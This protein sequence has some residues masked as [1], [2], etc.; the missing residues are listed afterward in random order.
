MFQQDCLT[1]PKPYKIP[2]SKIYRRWKNKRNSVFLFPFEM[3]T[4]W[5]QEEGTVAG[6]FTGAGDVSHPRMG[7]GWW[8]GLEM[9]P[10]MLQTSRTKSHLL[11]RLPIIPCTSSSQQFFVCLFF[12]LLLLLFFPPFIS[13]FITLGWICELR[14]LGA[15]DGD[16]KAPKECSYTRHSLSDYIHQ[17]QIR[18]GA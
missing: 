17:K 13:F 14:L 11:L 16:R 7:M 3:G 4:P 1:D 12:P 8:E 9:I 15:G 5:A 10:A 18:F 6:T 2:I